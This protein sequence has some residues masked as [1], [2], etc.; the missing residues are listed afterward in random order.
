[1]SGEEVR[2]SG[3][4]AGGE[5]VPIPDP[6]TNADPTRILYQPSALKTLLPSH[7]AQRPHQRSTLTSRPESY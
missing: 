4:E 3:G 6:Q 1:M 2:E 7:R 5:P